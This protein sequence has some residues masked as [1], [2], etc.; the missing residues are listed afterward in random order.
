MVTGR[1]DNINC[2][3]SL[4]EKPWM[5]AGYAKIAGVVMAVGAIVVGCAVLY[6]LENRLHV[7]LIF[8]SRDMKVYFAS[9][10][11]VAE[12]GRLY[13][14]VP[15]EYPLFANMIFAITRLFANSIH[16]GLHGFYLVYMALGFS[17]YLL[18]VTTVM[19]RLGIYAALVWLTPAPIYFALYRFDIYPA[20][21]TLIAL[22]AI[23]RSA[24]LQGA[25]CLGV[26]IALKGYA[27]AFMPAY[28][29]FLRYQ[30]G[31]ATAINASV[32][33]VA[34]ALL[35]VIVVLL[36]AGPQG[37]LD[38]L[39]FHAIRTLNGVSTYD[40][41]NDLLGETVIRPDGDIRGIAYCLQI[42]C[43]L[44]A[45][46]MRPRSFDAL[47]DAFLFAAL[48]L[49]SF[50]V[51]YSP[52][53]LLWV[54]PVVCFTTSPMLLLSAICFSWLTYLHFPIGNDLWVAGQRMFPNFMVV[55][56]SSVRL[57]MMLLTARSF[58]RPKMRDHAALR[59]LNP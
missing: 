8:D 56:V 14:E 16:P 20:A 53:Y 15:S 12:G 32:L 34:P 46:A 38:P 13:R 21:A 35:A 11:W 41:I 44:L 2:G 42:G 26:A 39:K 37:V 19:V 43:V 10:S 27:L 55:L 57:L 36:F 48:G 6:V 29:V 47:V 3:V 7:R 9:A 22:F 5:P 18:L 33:A 51:F 28:F 31:L 1:A 54:L 23:K 40:A 45:A 49:M 58:P 24:Y 50:S 25:L 59:T 30:R 17:V 4:E 52:Q